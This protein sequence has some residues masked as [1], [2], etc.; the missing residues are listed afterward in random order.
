M[1][2]VIPVF[3]DQPSNGME[4]ERRGYGLTIPLPSL[5]SENLKEAITQ[6][7]NDE[8]FAK[9][10]EKHGDLVMDQMNSPL[11]R[12]I[13]WIEY[14]MRHPGMKH[15]RSPVHDLHWT[16][17]FLLDVIAFVALIVSIVIFVIFVACRCC[18][19]VVCGRCSG[20][21]AK[22]KKQ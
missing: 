2:V 6:V 7:L 10:A 17:Y 11:E 21:T 12:A 22:L 4:A 16:Q 8:S 15:M 19:R 13:W 14:A 18:F 3:G 9:N 20:K 5:T 1:Q